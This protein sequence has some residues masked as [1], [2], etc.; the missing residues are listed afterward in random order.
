MRVSPR[1][2]NFSALYR[3]RDGNLRCNAANWSIF[4]EEIGVKGGS[5]NT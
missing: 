2:R 5:V 1:E 4:D 3:E